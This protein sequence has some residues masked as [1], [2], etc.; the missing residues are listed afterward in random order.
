MIVVWS[1][2]FGEQK[3]LE[4]RTKQT[5]ESYI[6]TSYV[7]LVGSIMSSCDILASS[8]DDQTPPSVSH[9]LVRENR[10]LSEKGQCR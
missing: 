7:P 2:Y 8:V 3:G 4:V 10:G 6:N 1:S 5:P 9:I